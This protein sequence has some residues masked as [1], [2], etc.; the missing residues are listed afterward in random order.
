MRTIRDAG[1]QTMHPAAEDHPRVRNVHL[2]HGWATR[3]GRRHRRADPGC[4]RVRVGVSAQP[5]RR[6]R[7]D[8]ASCPTR[9]HR[10]PS[11][12]RRHAP[13]GSQTLAVVARPYGG[14]LVGHESRTACRRS[15]AIAREVALRVGRCSSQLRPSG[16]V[17]ERLAR[18]MAASVATATVARQTTRRPTS[19][20]APGSRRRS[21]S[22]RRRRP[23]RRLAA[24]RRAVAHACRS[25]RAPA[26]P[27]RRRGIPP[28][29]GSSSVSTNS[30]TSS[31]ACAARGS[32][33][34][35]R[36][37]S[38][39]PPVPSPWRGSGR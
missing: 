19:R 21:R 18:D 9:W 20:S 23:R 3:S 29:A 2:A 1:A 37:R 31:A 7:R 25:R 12:G 36:P 4:R 35:R 10:R 26:G 24:A 6:V 38:R 11:S 33:P 8:A 34:G 28:V 5:D 17:H 32:S 27:S 15:L 13:T 22:A 14:R 30:P 16:E 39:P